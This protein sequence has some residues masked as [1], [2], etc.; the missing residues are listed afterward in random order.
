[1]RSEI[2][3][4][5]LL[6]EGEPLTVERVKAAMSATFSAHDTSAEEYIV[7]PGAQGAVGHDMGSGPI[8][9]HTP[10]VVDIWPRDNA[11]AVFTE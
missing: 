3:G 9:P 5:Q 6:L 1:M 11:S 8:P 2:S 4:D 7:A 10:V